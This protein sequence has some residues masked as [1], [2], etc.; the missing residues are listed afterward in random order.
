MATGVRNLELK[1]G[2][3]F[4]RLA[5]PVAVQHI[6]GKTEFN[7]PLGGDRSRALDD[8]P[9]MI[10]AMKSEIRAAKAQLAK[11]KGDY[12]PSLSPKRRMSPVEVAHQHLQDRLAVDDE[13]RDTG[14]SLIGVGSP[15]E[16]YVRQL[17][18]LAIGRRLNPLPAPIAIA[19]K[20][21]KRN[22]ELENEAATLRLLA[23]A[24]LVALDTEML[25]D[26]GEADPV[27]P[28]ELLPPP[29]APV[30]A[31]LNDR[32]VGRDST[33]SLSELLPRFATEKNA[34]P[35]TRREYEVA[36]RM[37]EEFLGE[38]RAAY[39]ITKQDVLDY[40]NAL[41]R[42]PSNYTKRFPGLTLPQAVTANA[43]R[44]VP[45]PTLSAV[46]INDK[47]LA[48]LHSILAWCKNNVITPDNVASEIR[49]AVAKGSGERPRYPFPPADLAAIF[50]KPVDDIEKHWAMLIALFSGARASE[51]A[52]MKLDS[53]REVRRILCFEIEEMTKNG[54]SRRAVPVHGMLLELGLER[55]IADLRGVGEERLFPSWY[56]QGA[57]GLEDPTRTINMPFAN[58]LPR[59]FNRTYLRNVGILHPK[60]K[61][62][63]F[64]HTMK[65]A[66]TRAAVPR[67][68][69]DEIT[70]QYDRSS[71][72]G[73]IHDG[74]VE[75][76][77]AAINSV[78][79]DGFDA[80]K[81]KLVK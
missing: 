55:R 12:R 67:S 15:D 31:S 76:M 22:G 17:R 79:F 8:L 30:P 41:V 25:R 53:V 46:T 36:V 26:E 73:Y 78:I 75:A 27:I 72:A 65:S 56:A 74:S 13:I 58:F 52:Q 7:E 47:W 61:Y 24:E 66:L 1:S 45:F 28:P 21:A 51:I 6:L 80:E 48:R 71:G 59:W 62:H 38:S 50:E 32:I 81:L 33:K 20:W 40:K 77:H 14:S 16:D 69:S 43:A 68:I 34:K 18:E 60:K 57:K 63:S 64:R 70:G 3:Y 10:A 23:K 39:A 35:G 37:F 42:T 29:R 44:K 9:G 4:A 54:A 49:V 11:P 2:R 5:V 19:M